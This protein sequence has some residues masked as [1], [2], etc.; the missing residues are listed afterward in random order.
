[1]IDIFINKYKSEVGTAIW[2]LQ[3]QIQN[4]FNEAGISVSVRIYKSHDS[5]I[6]IFV[7][8][9]KSS[10]LKSALKLV[11]GDSHLTIRPIEKNHSFEIVV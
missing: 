5:T 9:T 2:E 4:E 6:R 8:A 1:M 3:R 7:W 11:S 10:D